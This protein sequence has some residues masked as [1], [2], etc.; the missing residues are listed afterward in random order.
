MLEIPLW[1]FLAGGTLTHLLRRCCGRRASCQDTRWRGACGFI[2]PVPPSILCMASTLCVWSAG[3]GF[4]DHAQPPPADGLLPAGRTH[5]TLWSWYWADLYG[6]GT[7][8][9]FCSSTWGPCAAARGFCAGENHGGE[10]VGRPGSRLLPP[11]PVWLCLGRAGLFLGSVPHPAHKGL[12]LRS[13]GAPSLRLLLCP[14]KVQ[15]LRS[16]DLN[17]CFEL[18]SWTESGCFPHLCSSVQRQTGSG[19]TSQSGALCDGIR[20]LRV[21]RAS[22]CHAS[23][24]IRT[25][26]I[27]VPQVREWRLREVKDLA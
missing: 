1:T 16:L 18:A 25:L 27:S 8:W 17:C 4:C 20:Q 22:A 6:P 19:E 12:P 5:L 10:V 2:R 13:P 11:P 9:D 15:T 7:G 3:K 24:R 26:T 14:W 23:F 21:L